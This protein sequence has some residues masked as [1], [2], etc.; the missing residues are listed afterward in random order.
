MNGLKL[1]EFDAKLIVKGIT[2]G[3]M[4]GTLAFVIGLFMGES[5]GRKEVKDAIIEKGFYLVDD[6]YAIKGT[7]GKFKITTSLQE[8]TK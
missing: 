3:I 6:Q 7:Y 8:N 5:R 2:T 1:D 4:M